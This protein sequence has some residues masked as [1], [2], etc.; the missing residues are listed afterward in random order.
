MKSQV[1]F[2][3]GASKGLGLTLVKKLLQAGHKVAATSRSVASLVEKID[4]TETQFLPLE[5]HLSNPESVRKAMAQTQKK[6]G[7]V[8]VVVNNAGYGHFGAVEELSDSEA[9][10]NFDVNVFGTL[11][12]IREALP[13]MRE[14][15]AGHIF[16]ISSVGGY[17][18]SFP[19]VG[20]Y[21]AT[22]FAVA[23]MSEGLAAEVK[24]FGIQVTIVYPGY[25][26]TNFLD[27]D[28]MKS[29]KQSIAAYEA[30]QQSLDFHSNVMNGN[31]AG[32]PEKAAEALLQ[33]AQNPE[34]PLHL[35]LG[36]D[37]FKMAQEK[38][39]LVESELTKWKSLSE[40]TDLNNLK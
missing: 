28:S 23:G 6:W 7:A 20:I 13:L 15:K 39:Q 11:N 22:K 26:R 9:R 40:S 8:D 12:V 16:N 14:K 18:G 31:Q 36:K 3:T 21:C 25:F 5:V 10:E 19:G 4:A 38:I 1:W 32:D 27:Q 34:A 35:F 30:S 17:S 29:P 24:D 37:A 33:V 2:V